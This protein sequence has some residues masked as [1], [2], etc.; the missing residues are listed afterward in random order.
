MKL[1][2]SQS[3]KDSQL[4]STEFQLLNLSPKVNL[5][6]THMP[7]YIPENNMLKFIIART[8]NTLT[9]RQLKLKYKSHT[10]RW[11]TSTAN[12]STGV[13][14]GR[15]CAKTEDEIRTVFWFIMCFTFPVR[16][17]ASLNKSYGIFYKLTA[18]FHKLHYLIHDCLQRQTH[19]VLMVPH[20][21]WKPEFFNC[22]NSSS[23]FVKGLR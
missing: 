20:I 23:K 17:G 21:Y 13:T 7:M 11:E 4:W 12:Q 19:S 6:T 9:F 8:L 3:G 5:S 1:F 14:Y 10:G 15:T 16:L 18:G 2:L 22:R